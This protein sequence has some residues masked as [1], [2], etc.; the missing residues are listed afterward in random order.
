[1]EHSEEKLIPPTIIPKDLGHGKLSPDAIESIR[2]ALNKERD[3]LLNEVP[4][5]EANEVVK[6][7]LAK[8]KKALKQRLTFSAV[9]VAT[10]A[11]MGIMV[12]KIT[13][14]SDDL[15]SRELAET[16][17]YVLINHQTDEM[18]GRIEE[19]GR[20]SD[21]ERTY[22]VAVVT[23]DGSPI[24]IYWSSGAGK[25]HFARD[26]VAPRNCRVACDNDI[27]ED[28]WYH[29]SLFPKE[30]KKEFAPLSD[31]IQKPF[32]LVELTVCMPGNTLAFYTLIKGELFVEFKPLLDS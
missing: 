14:S 32:S 17:R 8:Q 20:F 1:M 30:V 23:V 25:F 24:C 4:R 13:P 28:Y 29:K 3:L 12:V 10:N 21:D 7:Y 22:V 31:L 27:R 2:A 9:I 11:D 18:I 6:R 19:S 15:G 26:E 5:E 16:F